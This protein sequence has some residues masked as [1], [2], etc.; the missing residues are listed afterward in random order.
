[1]S[2]AIQQR[3]NRSPIL[4][5]EGKAYLDGIE[6][7]DGI[8]L[9]IKF[10][11]VMHTFTPIGDEIQSSHWSGGKIT[12]SLTRYR[13]NK[14]LIIKIKEYMETGKTP[15]FQFFGLVHDKNSDYCNDGQGSIPVQAVGCVMTGDIPLL[16]LD[17]KGQFMEDDINF[18]IKNVIL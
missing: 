18:N 11:P 7:L 14:F 9:N 3:Y 1:M 5:R 6:V 15:E 10:T 8:K 16:A 2:S 4:I 17:T 13:S 12:G